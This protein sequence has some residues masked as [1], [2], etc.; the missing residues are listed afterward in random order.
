[1][2][3]SSNFYEGKSLADFLPEN[4]SKA[5]S[6]GKQYSYCQN[7]ETSANLQPTG[8]K[9]KTTTKP[10]DPPDPKKEAKKKLLD[11]QQKKEDLK[12]E[13]DKIRRKLIEEITKT[14]ADQEKVKSHT[15]KMEQIERK[16][17]PIYQDLV[18]QYH[19]LTVVTFP[20]K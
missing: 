7:D 13:L 12:K 18:N 1:M 16:W 8:T 20:V 4:E 6:R 10:P 5:Q 19:I 11:L 3:T 14:T 9:P 2:A 17:R 15:A